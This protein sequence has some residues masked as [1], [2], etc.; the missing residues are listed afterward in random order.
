L[1]AL[2]TGFLLRNR[3]PAAEVSEQGPLTATIS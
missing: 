3:P 2:S 1:V